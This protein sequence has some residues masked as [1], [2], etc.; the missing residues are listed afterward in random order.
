MSSKLCNLMCEDYANVSN[1]LKNM[2]L[3]R[4]VVSDEPDGGAE[5]EEENITS[6]VMSEYEGELYLRRLYHAIHEQYIVVVNDRLQVLR[7]HW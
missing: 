4:L 2:L 5:E 1:E 3:V 7:L 6:K